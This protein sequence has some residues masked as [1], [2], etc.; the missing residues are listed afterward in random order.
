[1]MSV[2]QAG[3]T[4]SNDPTETFRGMRDAYLDFMAKAMVDAVNTEGYAEATGAMLNNSLTMTAPFREAMEKSMQQVLQQL[5]LPSRLDIV[6]LSERFTN[7]EMR[8][9]DIDAKLDRIEKQTHAAPPA[10]KAA[11]AKPGSPKAKPE[12]Q[13]VAKVP[14]TRRRKAT[15]KQAPTRKRAAKKGTRK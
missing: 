13:A 5:S 2:D 4:K 12:M 7:Q 9:D 15:V 10:A 3:K 14:T 11:P 1:M 8:L 6:A